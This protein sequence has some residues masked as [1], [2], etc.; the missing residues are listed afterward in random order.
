V[1]VVRGSDRLTRA[2]ALAGARGAELQVVSRWTGETEKSLRA[3]FERAAAS[4]AI[5]FFDDADDLFGRDGVPPET[6]LARLAAEYPER[7]IVGVRDES[8]RRRR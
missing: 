2:E 8:R 7:V 5:L 3:L 4:G 1:D 6:A